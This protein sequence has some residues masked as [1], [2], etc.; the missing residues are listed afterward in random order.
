MLLLSA[1]PVL[2]D[3]TPWLQLHTADRLRGSL[4]CASDSLPIADASLGLVVLQHAH[5][6]CADPPQLIAECVRVLMPGGRL[7]VCGF[8]PWSWS[9]WQWRRHCRYRPALWSPR[10][11]ARQLRL[12]QLGCRPASYLPWQTSFMETRVLPS[13]LQALYLLEARRDPPGRQPLRPLRLPAGA[14]PG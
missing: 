4:R 12:E 11:L 7:L 9:R 5:E 6:F 1:L 14:L 3:S 2:R 10:Q 13:A 8:N